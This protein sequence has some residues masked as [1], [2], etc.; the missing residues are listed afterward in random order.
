MLNKVD[1]RDR[2]STF[3]D[4]LG[5]AIDRANTS[6]SALARKAGVD[7][8]TISQLLRDNGPRLPNAQLVAECAGALGVSADWL[9]GLSDRPE[10]ATDL[11]AASL[12]F[13]VAPR[14]LVDE[15]IFAWHQEAKGYKIRHVPAGMPDMLKSD[16]MLRWEY[17]PSLGRT[18]EQ[19]V[20]ASRDRLNWMRS[21]G[22]DYE[23]AVPVHDLRAMAQ[24]EGYYQGLPASVRSG[25]LDRLAELHEQLYPRLRLH[26]F[27]ARRLF[28]APV[29]IFGPLLGVI[30]LG[31]N[32]LAFRDSDRVDLITQHFDRLVREAVIGDREIPDYVEMLRRGL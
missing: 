31:S 7:R 5:Q 9:L 27:D 24:A 17:N 12:T 21:S 15:R 10:Q 13:T 19:A 25:Q 6:Q 3:R 30:Y 1:K 14:A 20:G 23:I 16:D 4:R 18:T 8:S 26:L 22:S 32:Y 28:S 11:V 29:T 2:A